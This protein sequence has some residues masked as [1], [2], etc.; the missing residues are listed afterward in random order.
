MAEFELGAT[1]YRAT[2]DVYTT[3]EWGTRR[4][5]LHVVEVRVQRL[6]PEGAWV[7]SAWSDAEKWVTPRTHWCSPTKEAAIENLHIRK[8]RH[9]WHARRRLKDA[10]FAL[11]YLEAA[12]PGVSPH[13]V[14]AFD[15]RD[16]FKD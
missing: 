11:N 5:A 10:E 2:I 15:I 14:K 8:A 16:V 1:W 6:T 9:V 13:T 7:K 3:D 4:A 12:S